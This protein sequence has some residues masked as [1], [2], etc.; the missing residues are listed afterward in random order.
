MYDEAHPLIHKLRAVCLGLGNVIEKEAW[1][2]C[3]FRAVDG[4]MFAMTDCNHHDS[5]HIGVWV[6]APAMVQEILINSDARRFFR[7]PYMGH[8]GWVGVRLE[9]KADW[10]QIAAILK[11]GY[12]MS[13]PVKKNAGGASRAKRVVS[14]VTRAKQSMR[15]R[16]GGKVR[17]DH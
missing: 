10:A 15:P 11:D 8:K 1:G 7:P 13:L 3:T 14:P 16:R 6:K 4:S 9:G 12:Q 2:E 17:H 5:G